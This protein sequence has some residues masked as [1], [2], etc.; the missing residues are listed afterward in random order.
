LLWL[1][2]NIAIGLRL[3]FAEIQ[4]HITLGNVLYY[5][6]VVLSGILAYVYI[7]KIWRKK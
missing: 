1:F 6:W 5:V 3:R 4:Q 2:I 7:Q